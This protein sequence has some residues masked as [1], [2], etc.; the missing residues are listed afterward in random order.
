M[1]TTSNVLQSS[2]G[3]LVLPTVIFL[4]FHMT[5]EH[6]RYHKRFIFEAAL[7][8][9]IYCL[10]FLILGVEI[11][12]ISWWPSTELC[13]RVE[14]CGRSQEMKVWSYCTRLMLD[15]C[16]CRTYDE[17]SHGGAPWKPLTAY[18]IQRCVDPTCCER[19]FHGAVLQDNY[20]LHPISTMEP[21]K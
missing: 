5:L 2:F 10:Q 6:A 3:L 4:C 9:M 17:V 11:K 15:I 18:L 7:L 19:G 21:T 20:L 16:I 13:F 14:L 8:E 1:C 12:L